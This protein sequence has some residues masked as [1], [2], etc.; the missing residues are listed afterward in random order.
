LIGDSCSIA[1]GV[2]YRREKCKYGISRTLLWRLGIRIVVLP[3]A[4]CKALEI[5]SPCGGLQQHCLDE[6]SSGYI[7]LFK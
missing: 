4:G 5:L 3:G 2:D 6:V 1:K 7:K